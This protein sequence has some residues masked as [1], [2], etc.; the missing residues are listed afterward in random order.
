MNNKIIKLEESRQIEYAKYSKHIKTGTIILISSI[1]I[2]I[3][4]A[5]SMGDTSYAV[6]IFFGVVG[7]IIWGIFFGLASNINHKYSKEV[8]TKLVNILL[9]DTYS[10]YLYDMNSSIP[11]NTVVSSGLV[12]RPDR[13]KGNDYIKA[14]Y[15]DVNVEVSDIH[16]ERRE[17]RTDSRGN[18]TTTYTTFFR[19]RFYIFEFRRDLKNELRI[20]ENRFLGFSNPGRGFKKYETESIDFNK[21]FNIYSTDHQFVFY[22]ITPI[23]LEKIQEL[24]KLHGGHL[25]MSFTGNKLLIAVNDN[26][27]YLE[28][29]I[30]KPITE[31]TV[32]YLRADT[33][34]MA[35]IINELRLST[36]KFMN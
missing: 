30:K 35:S 17:T 33:D 15:K 12:S 25:S 18:T 36:S 32:K 26:R 29:N 24:E 11:V 20:I 34:I 16:Y 9:A 27:D 4:L 3:I 7:F 5:L 1:V 6:P 28:T 14:T 22:I 19:G 21:K 10:D 13:S 23:I 8:K 31:E 2:G